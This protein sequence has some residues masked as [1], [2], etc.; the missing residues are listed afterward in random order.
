VVVA[1][2]AL[3]A[4]AV[5]LVDLRRWAESN[6]GRPGIRKFRRVIALAEP[7]AE[8]PM[9]SRLRVL[10]VLGG[11]PRPAAQVSIH[12]DRG[13]FVGRPDL[14][15]ETQR[16]G[17][18]YDGATHRTTLA[19]DNRRQNL[20]LGAGVRLLRFTADDVKQRPRAVVEQV[21]AMLTTPPFAGKR[22]IPAHRTAPIA[23][24]RRYTN[25]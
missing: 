22:T 11:L 3:H 1:D 6:G 7:A 20:M 15:Y 9:E 4:S 24:K 21:R 16:L 25:A 13:R 5:R 23:G 18:E 8:S 17:I 19:D 12:D 2:A 10:L 14:Y